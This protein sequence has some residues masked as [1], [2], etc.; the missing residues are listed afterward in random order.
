MKI[1][2]LSIIVI[3][4]KVGLGCDLRIFATLFS[5]HVH[6]LVNLLSSYNQ[7]ISYHML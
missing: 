4:V 3:D 7:I 2:T 5:V 1:F 6:L